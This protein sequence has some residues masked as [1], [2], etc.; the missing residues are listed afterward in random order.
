[1]L[2]DADDIKTRKLIVN[3][4][5][6]EIIY[7]EE[8][9]IITYNFSDT[10]NTDK[11]TKEYIEEI[12]RQSISAVN[13]NPSSCL[14]LPCPLKTPETQVSG[15][16]LC[17]DLGLLRRQDSVAH[18]PQHFVLELMPVTSGARSFVQA[19]S[20]AITLAQFATS[21]IVSTTEE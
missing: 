9:V 1:M 20:L 5:I 16:F 13:S 12:E 6:R 10:I 8:K 17:K 3:M 19:H 15:V 2:S 18:L 4:F 21:L 11:S 7:Y 14:D